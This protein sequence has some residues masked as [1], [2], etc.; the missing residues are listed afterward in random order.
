MTIELDNQIVYVIVSYRYIELEEMSTNVSKL[1][2]RYAKKFIII[3]NE[4]F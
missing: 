3:F 1:F 4:K 2:I